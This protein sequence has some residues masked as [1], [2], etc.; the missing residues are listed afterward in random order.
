MFLLAEKLDSSFRETTGEPYML[1]SVYIT[2]KYRMPHR[3]QIEA[4]MDEGCVELKRPCVGCHR[5]L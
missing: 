1:G 3:N 2:V 4:S 5:L